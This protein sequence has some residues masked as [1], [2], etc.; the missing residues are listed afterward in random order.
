MAEREKDITAS[1]IFWRRAA[2]ES[3]SYIL[4]L[5]SK[6]MPVFANKSALKLSGCKYRKK[7]PLNMGHIIG[8]EKIKPIKDACGFTGVCKKCV[9]CGAFNKALATRKSTELTGFI[10]MTKRGRAAEEIHLN[11]KA[12]PLRR[13][14]R[15]YVIMIMHDITFSVKKANEA[16]AYSAQ[17]A[18]LFN[19]TADAVY[20][21]GV[22]GKKAGRF[23]DANKAALKELGYTKKELLSLEV[24]DVDT[25]KQKKKHAVIISELMRSGRCVFETRHVRKNGSTYAV[26]VSASMFELEGEKLIVSTARNVEERGIKERELKESEEK[27]RGLFENISSAFALHR[28]ITDRR[29]RPVDY[30]YV[31]VNRKFE[32][33]IGRKAPD[34][35]GKKVTEIVPG[36]VKDTFDWIGVFGRVALTGK[37]A[38][39]ETYSA[40]HNKWFS[41]QAYCPKKSHFAVIFEDITEKKKIYLKVEEQKRYAEARAAITEM[42]IIPGFEGE[43]ILNVLKITGE[44][45][46]CKLAF[47][48]RSEGG[49][50]TFPYIWSV[51]GK[52]RILSHARIP[53]RNDIT[54][55]KPG[56][57]TDE[58]ILRS[59]KNTVLKRVLKKLASALGVS[60][61]YTDSCVA[62]GK[63][64]G[65]FVF[66][67]AKGDFRSEQLEFI[68]VTSKIAGQMLERAAFAS[69]LAASEEQYRILSQNS[70]DIIWAL[71]KDMK[72]TFI[73]PS[74]QRLHGQGYKELLGK[75]LVEALNPEEKAASYRFESGPDSGVRTINFEA[76]TADKN[77]RE[78]WLES[79]GRAVVSPEGVITGFAGSTRD[80]TSRKIMEK[81][82]YNS[83][84]YYRALIEGSADMVFVLNEK[85]VIKYASPNVKQIIGYPVNYFLGRDFISLDFAR[86][87]VK[88]RLISTFKKVIESG[89]PFHKFETFAETAG[90]KPVSIEMT[91][92]NMLSDKAVSGIVV[93]ARDATE[94]KKFEESLKQAIWSLERSNADLEQFAYAASH[95]LKEPLRMIANY[96]EL[97]E[98]RYIKILPEEA[99]EFMDFALDG[100]KRM[101]R[102]IQAILMYSRAG[103]YPAPEKP[104]DLNIIVKELYEGFKNET[105]GLVINWS[106]LP[107]LMISEAEAIQLFQNIIGN[108][109]KFRAGDNPVIVINAE[110]QDDFWRFSIKDNG[111]GFD[112]QYREKIFRLFERLHSDSEYQG[113][114]LGLTLCKKIVENHRGEISAESAEG[115]GTT[116]TFTLPA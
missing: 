57:I 21:H 115:K 39:F 62:G 71:D 35:R 45:A 106:K 94:R 51:S 113:T 70:A 116:I 50:V 6:G 96:L 18:A 105:G 83:E 74:V 55:M 33:F 14:G 52:K 102:L 107:K 44:A 97:I 77:R 90:G 81:L 24:E 41:V 60:S 22:E 25:E 19:N 16:E 72:I 36:V 46:G 9:V 99:K 2:E 54:E 69:K 59:V 3:P 8:C 78:I 64:I 1:D 37:P 65:T 110:R 87:S 26:E 53:A 76:R 38:R 73:S 61:A 101:Y 79:K 28:V 114:G 42:Q 48:S 98:M 108:A 27:Y 43:F 93:N 10:L 92:R 80:I 15:A 49:Y 4:V 31:E 88:E 103:K 32:E 29:G 75:R 89:E 40:D 63:I 86:G 34:I 7:L 5:N 85:G 104:I 66:I 17:I 82:L 11:I 12:I 112:P 109:V 23:L 67:P 58:D 68:R 30:E 95:D 56:L 47:W 111:I 20:V 13:E 91:A 84:K 100:T